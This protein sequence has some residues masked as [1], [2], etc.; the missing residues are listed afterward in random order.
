MAFNAVAGIFILAIVFGVGF[1]VASADSSDALVQ[2]GAFGFDEATQ[3]ATAA[4]QAQASDDS[5]DEGSSDT[6]DA[7]KASAKAESSIDQS[8][9]TERSIRTIDAGLRMVDSKEKAEHERAK[10]EKRARQRRAKADRVAEQQRI[11]A[12]STAAIERVRTQ[13][14]K[15]GVVQKEIVIPDP[16]SIIDDAGS[17]APKEEQSEKAQQSEQAQESEQG[18]EPAQDQGSE[19]AQE[20]SETADS[21]VEVQA[22]EYDLPAVDWTVGRNAFVAEWTQRIDAY[23]A[24]SPLEGYGYAFAEAAWDN[25]VDP[26]W[27]PAI[28]NTESSKGEVCFLPCNAWGW[29]ES[30]WDDWDSAIRAHVK[31]LAE[32]YGYSITYEAACI[33]CPPNSDF[34]YSA[35]I[36]EMASI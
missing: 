12:E 24:K 23:L 6:A 1:R 7:S 8:F 29:G 20:S 10:A 28:S 36:G 9:L 11:A 32:V 27:S 3:K 5:D 25:G 16:E 17:P 21:T 15:Q 35:T 14:K 34:W 30:A 13:K 33:Y 19:Q 31:G 18:S 22:Y 4:T 2:A 26:R